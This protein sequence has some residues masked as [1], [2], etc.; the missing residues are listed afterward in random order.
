[1]GYEVTLGEESVPETVVTPPYRPPELEK[2]EP[3]NV[4]D[5]ANDLWSLACTIFEILTGEL[6][7]PIE[8]SQRAE[9]I[10]KWIKQSTHRDFVGRLSA[11]IDEK[12]PNYT[13]NP[14]TL[15]VLAH[16]IADC[17]RLDPSK[18]PSAE[19]IADLIDGLEVV[20]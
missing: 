19:K 3:Q 13:G 5:Y 1:M 9:L 4:I 2:G 20:N 18:R 6:L 15:K 14:T 7:F 8:D 16:I 17:L 11:W 10:D 12:F